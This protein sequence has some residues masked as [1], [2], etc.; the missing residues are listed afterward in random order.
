[1]TVNSPKITRTANA[2]FAR[3]PARPVSGRSFDDSDWIR[4]FVRTDRIGNFLQTRYPSDFDH[5][6]WR[7]SCTFGPKGK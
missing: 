2:L 3:M 1:M 7:D 6:Q 5:T 4:W